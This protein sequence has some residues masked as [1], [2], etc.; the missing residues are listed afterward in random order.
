MFSVVGLSQR[1]VKPASV[2]ISALS[3]RRRFSGGRRTVFGA[4]R[5]VKGGGGR[6]R[7]EE[8]SWRDANEK[9]QR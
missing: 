9:K 5:M 8:R 4:H 6:P 7:K 1:S 3:I 2:D